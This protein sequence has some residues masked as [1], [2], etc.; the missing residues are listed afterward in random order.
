MFWFRREFNDS[1][2]S[3]L[4]LPCVGLNAAKMTGISADQL[5]IADAW[6]AANYLCAQPGA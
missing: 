1:L 3:G 5:C 2:F 4:D 6:A